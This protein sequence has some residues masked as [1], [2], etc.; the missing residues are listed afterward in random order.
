MWRHSQAAAKELGALPMEV[1]QAAFWS[2]DPGRT[3]GKFAAFGRL[4][5]ASDD[6]RRFVELEEWAN[7][8]E[9]L[10]YPA[11]KELVEDL[12]GSDL[13]G[14]GRWLFE[15]TSVSERLSAPAL[16]LTAERD[17][18]APPQTVAAGNVVA[19]RSGHVGMI[20]GSA[21]QALHQALEAFLTPCC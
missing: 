3:V 10:P 4:E 11:A 9:P 20:V 18:I 16:H 1:L 5:P 21:R 14:S 7:E 15:G 17:L 19:I 12:F 6:A 8:G 2:L 13:P